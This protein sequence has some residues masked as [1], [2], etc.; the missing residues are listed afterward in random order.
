MKLGDGVMG[1]VLDLELPLG[2]P[3]SRSAGHVVSRL[4]MSKVASLELPRDGEEGL[5]GY[6][7]YLVFLLTNHLDLLVAEADEV[8]T[9]MGGENHLRILSRCM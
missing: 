8:A 5:L 7:D 1:C 2:R 6:V 4:V 3:S 9:R